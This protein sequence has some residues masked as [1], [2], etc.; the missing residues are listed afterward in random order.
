MGAIHIRPDNRLARI[1][2]RLFGEG[3]I[4]GARSE[5]A[6]LPSVLWP[7][8]GCLVSAP[9]HRQ[10]RA[11]LAAELWPDHDEAA[12]RHCL[13]SALWRIRQALP[14]DAQLLAAAGDWIVMEQSPRLWIDAV[15]FRLRTSRALANPGCLADARERHRLAVALRHYDSAFLDGCDHE[16][17]A[18]ERERLRTL[19][20]D[21]LYELAT[22]EAQAEHWSMARDLARAL[23]EVEPLREDA[24]RLLITAYARCGNRALALKQY[25]TCEAVLA[26]QLDVAPMPDTIALGR[27]IGAAPMFAST[28]AEAHVI[29]LKRMRTD[30]LEIVAR[31]DRSLHASP[32]RTDPSSTCL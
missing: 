23:C 30:L 21:G 3:R 1:R 17:I 16:P 18:L 4:L 24:Q 28:S 20:L 31:I 19:Y 8:V 13:A 25:R 10:R 27:E 15:A 14:A 7:I 5:I 22:A 9:Q 2:V 32:S 12:A 11:V 29:E 26:E 6:T